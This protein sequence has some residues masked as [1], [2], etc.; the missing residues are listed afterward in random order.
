MPLHSSDLMLAACA[1]AAAMVYLLPFVV[2]WLRQVP[3]LNTLALINVALGWTVAGWVVALVMALRP[4][5]PARQDPGC[6]A[7][8]D[9]HNP[10]PGD[11]PGTT[12]PRPPAWAARPA[13]PGKG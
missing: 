1:D 13:E 8:E 4:A 12:T 6:P 3:D 10:R 7:E 9:R 5:G 2:G 11:R